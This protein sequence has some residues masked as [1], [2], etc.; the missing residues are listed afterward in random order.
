[1]SKHLLLSIAEIGGY[2]DFSAQYRSAGY[3]V[4]T[5]TS[6]RKAM[7]VIKKKKPAIVVAEFNFQSDFRDRTSSLE[8]MRSVVQRSPDIRVIVFYEKEYQHQF[9]RLL[10][11]HSFYETFAFPVPEQALQSCVVN[12]AKELSH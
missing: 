5:E 7:A 3:E 9:D 11:R 1:M 2:P 12:I 6:M 8:S 4:Q 10:E